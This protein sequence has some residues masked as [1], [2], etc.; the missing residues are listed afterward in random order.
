[1]TVVHHAAAEF[2]IGSDEPGA[3]QKRTP[4]PLGRLLPSALVGA[5]IAGG[6]AWIGLLRLV[7]WAV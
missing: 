5:L 6:L 2:T 3:E 4:E 1:M 7:S